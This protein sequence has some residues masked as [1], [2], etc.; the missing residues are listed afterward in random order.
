MRSANVMET[1]GARLIHVL[2]PCHSIFMARRELYTC[3]F[4]HKICSSIKYTL[5][6]FPS[7][8][9]VLY[10]FT[11]SPPFLSANTV[12]F[13]LLSFPFHYFVFFSFFYFL[14]CVLAALSLLLADCCAKGD[15]VDECFINL[16]NDYYYCYFFCGALLSDDEFS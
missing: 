14:I 10:S 12:F 11:L 6:V 7:C 1:H 15:G 13:F 5:L 16:G 8:S 4:V 3:N 9:M 2:E